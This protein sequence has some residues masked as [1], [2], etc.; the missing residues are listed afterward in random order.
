MPV[1][2]CVLAVLAQAPAAEPLSLERALELALAR[3]ERAQIAGQQLAAADGRLTQA[4]AFFFPSLTASGQYTRRAYEVTRTVSGQDVT[5][6][7]FNALSAA[8]VLRWSLFDAR[9]IANYQ[10]ASADQRATRFEAAEARRRLSFEAAQAFLLTLGYELVHEAAKRRVALAEANLA[11]AKAR[12]GAGL[13]SSNDVTRSTLELATARR[14]EANAGGLRQT[15]RLNLALL[16]DLE[17]SQ[18]GPLEAPTAM[19]EVAKAQPDSVDR[20]AIDQARAARLDVK[21]LSERKAQAEAL[22]REPLLRLVPVLGFTGQGTLTNETGLAGRPWAASIGID[23]TWALFDG[24]NRYGARDERAANARI[25]A[26]NER[27]NERSVAI[28]VQN[29]LVALAA[30]RASE[31][32]AGV[33]VDASRLNAQETSALYRQGL[34]TALQQADAVQSQFE[35]EVALVQ[36][37]YAVLL[38]LLGLRAALGVDPLGREVQP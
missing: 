27:L 24:G 4:R 18:L 13:A 2:V 3:N 30:S 20:A 5:V 36:E 34:A 33:E 23:L 25:A 10:A 37:R 1:L 19:F 11:D 17:P 12:K 21:G 15:A 28:E 38:S 7:Q 32:Q 9:N 16:L 14:A 35:A 26:L 6:L 31:A 29:A 8:A 22:A